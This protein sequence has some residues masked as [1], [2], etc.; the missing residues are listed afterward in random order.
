MKRVPVLVLALLLMGLLGENHATDGIPPLPSGL[1]R[2]VFLD[3]VPHFYQKKDECGPTSF[4]MVLRYW[5]VPVT[6]E[7]VDAGSH[8]QPGQGATTGNL[9]RVVTGL[10]LKVRS[11]SGDLAELMKNLAQKRPVIVGQWFNEKA[12]QVGGKGHLRV[13]IGYDYDQRVVF[14][15]DPSRKGPSVLNFKEF[16]SLWDRRDAKE[17]RTHNLMIVIT[18]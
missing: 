6:R 8:W 15:N 17:S 1:P 10:G 12:K 11:Y 18:K 13:A 7:E 3:K 2:H 5:H 4:G 14:I 9:I 16:L